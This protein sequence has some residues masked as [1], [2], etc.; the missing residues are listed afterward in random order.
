MVRPVATRWNSM[1]ESIGRALYLRPAIEKLLDLPQ[2]NSTRGNRLRRFK[3]KDAEWDI[4]MR[5][6]AILKV[7]L[8]SFA[9]RIDDRSRWLL[10][11][12]FS[13]QPSASP[14]QMFRSS[15]R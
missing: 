12:S 3:L 2:H 4:L 13:V 15:T 9:V 8:P 11:S 6:H 1:A 5:L 7:C 10:F 14:F